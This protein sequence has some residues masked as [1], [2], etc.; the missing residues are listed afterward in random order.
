MPAFLLAVAAVAILTVG[1]CSNSE[2]PDCPDGTEHFVEYQLFMGR[3][4]VAGEIVDDEAWQV[5]LEDTVI[6][7][8][9]DGLTVLDGRGHWRDSQDIAYQERSKLLIVLAPPGDAQMQLTREI[10]DEYKRRFGQESVLRV[11]SDACVSF[12]WRSSFRLPLRRHTW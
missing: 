12:S 4:N 8:F 10:S 2:K 5:F 7:R 9:P 1:A 3:S 6:P 11:V